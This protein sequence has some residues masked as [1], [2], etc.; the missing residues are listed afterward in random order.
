MK[1]VYLL[2]GV[3][4][5][6]VLCA[7]MAARADVRL[8]GTITGA[9]INDNAT[10][11]KGATCILNGVTV[12][13]HLRVEEGASLLTLGSTIYG[14]V[15]ANKAEAVEIQQHS[16]VTD[17]IKSHGSVLVGL[18]TGSIVYGDFKCKDGTGPDEGRWG[19]GGSTVMG[20]V[21]CEKTVG[22][23]GILNSQINGDVRIKK[24]TGR[25]EIWTSVINGDV[26]V[27]DCLMQ[28]QPP[29]PNFIGI[30]STTIHGD[31]TYKHNDGAFPITFNVIDGDLRAENNDAATLFSQNTVGGKT[32][33]H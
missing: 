23:S 25:L 13:G 31:L 7:P 24:H 6:A 10:V 22:T 21:D 28:P 26:K 15:E 3:V 9:V 27:E 30:F 1:R 12:N 2:G 11:P 19:I 29:N 8:T 32:D 5:T 4:L 16:V 33:I 14:H 20:D 17:D 18:R